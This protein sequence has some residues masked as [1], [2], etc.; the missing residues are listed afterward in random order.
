[1]EEEEP[2]KELAEELELEKEQKEKPHVFIRGVP[3]LSPPFTRLG[4][5]TGNV[6]AS[7]IVVAILYLLQYI[8][9]IM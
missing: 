8:I 3:P 1:M 6:D 5:D 4:S 2:V 9:Y 7:G